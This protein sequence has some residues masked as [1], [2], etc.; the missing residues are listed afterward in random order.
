MKNGLNLYQKLFRFVVFTLSILTANLVSDFSSNYLVSYKNQYK[1]IP[2]TFVGMMLIVIVFY[3]LFQLL[4]KWIARFSKNVVNTGRSFAG[5]YLGLLLAF[6]AA[7]FVLMYFYLQVWYDKNL[8]DFLF[9][10]K[11]KELF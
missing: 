3:P 2:F 10:G 5:K 4:D 8:F 11:I 6:F 7:L 1:P 9:V